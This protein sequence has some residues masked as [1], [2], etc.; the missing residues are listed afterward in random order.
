MAKTSMICP[1][2]GAVGVPKTHTPGHFAIELL[3]WCFFLL[4][5]LIYSV[6]RL[7]G[8]KKVCASCEAENM[9]PLNSPRG[10]KLQEELT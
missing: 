1:N 6:W 8:R 5:G 7:A 2:C 10:R 3:L 9:V 4:P